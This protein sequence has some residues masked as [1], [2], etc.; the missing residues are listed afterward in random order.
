MPPQL[1][2]LQQL[3]PTK[4]PPVTIDLRTRVDDAETADDDLSFSLV[5]NAR[6]AG[7][8]ARGRLHG[9]FYADGQQQRRV[10]L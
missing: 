7:R 9:H 2:I 4:T 1:K 10:I 6:R 5:N 3:Q 8:T